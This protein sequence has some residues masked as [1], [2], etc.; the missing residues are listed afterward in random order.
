MRSIFD[1]SDEFVDKLTALRPM[2]ATLW[3]IAGH[4]H[5]W[6][7]FSPE[8]SQAIASVLTAYRDELGAQAPTEPKD[9]LAALVTR[10]YIDVELERIRERD[11]QADLNNITSPFQTIRMVFD[12]MDTKSRAGWE[13]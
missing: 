5:A 13:A 9:K 1:L 4:D 7:D 6:D 11:D 2:S 3:G 10:D 8:G 12:V